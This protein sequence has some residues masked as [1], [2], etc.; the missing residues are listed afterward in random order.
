M[1]RGTKEGSWAVGYI[2]HLCRSML[3]LGRTREVKVLHWALVVLLTPLVY[4]AT[5]PSTPQAWNAAL[6]DEWK[7]FFP[8]VV[9]SILWV[10]DTP[11]GLLVAYRARRLNTD[12]FNRSFTRLM[13]WMVVFFACGILKWAGSFFAIMDFDYLSILA[14]GVE[15]MAICSQF[16]SI[17]RNLG[18]WD[19]KN[20]P[21]FSRALDRFADRAEATGVQLATMQSDLQEIKEKV[22]QNPLTGGTMV[23]ES[24][25]PVILELKPTEGS[26]EGT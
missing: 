3:A 2:M 8:F 23:L 9:V 22:A 13:F 26:Q 21:A 14:S 4:A 7:I 5:L 18:E 17:L 15:V 19:P 10:L 11:L 24:K 6:H 20:F 1:R 12:R 16:A 25:D